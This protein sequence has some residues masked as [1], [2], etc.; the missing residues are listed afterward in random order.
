LP[1]GLPFGREHFVV[2][3]RKKASKEGNLNPT[4]NPLPFGKGEGSSLACILYARDGE[5][6][7]LPLPLLGKGRG[8]DRTTKT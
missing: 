8:T 6:A 7:R 4:P 5:L 2:V 3:E 1:F